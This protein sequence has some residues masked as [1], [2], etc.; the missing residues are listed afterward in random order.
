MK[1]LVRG[2]GDGVRRSA[3]FLASCGVHGFLLAWVMVSAA[4]EQAKP[5]QSIY[6]QLIR[7]NERRLIW[8]NLRAS[9]PNVAPAHAA[10]KPQPLRAQKKLD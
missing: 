2:Q 5:P 7:P 10:A 3:A 9:L 4:W 1:I 6:D 8:Y